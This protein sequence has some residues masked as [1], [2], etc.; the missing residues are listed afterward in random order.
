MKSSLGSVVYSGL[1][2]PLKRRVIGSC[3]VHSAKKR[4]GI[5]AVRTVPTR[6]VVAPLALEV[7]S[8][9]SGDVCI[10]QDGG[11]HG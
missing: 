2:T 5:N 11:E 3:V 8:S 4:W 1:A 10:T 7:V 9:S 6:Q